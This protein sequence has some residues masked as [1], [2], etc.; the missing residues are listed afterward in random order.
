[1]C[2]GENN[3]R[4]EQLKLRLPNEFLAIVP[5]SDNIK[6]FIISALTPLKERYIHSIDVDEENLVANIEVLT[7]EAYNKAVGRN[8][9]NVKLARDLT[10]WLINVK[11]LK[12]TVIMP[13]PEDEIREIIKT[14]VPEIKNDEVEIVRIARI[15]G[16]GSKVI[17]RW[18]HNA[19]KRLLASQ[20][21][22]GRDHDH[23]KEIQRE[24]IGEWLYFH[25]WN[26]D[27]EELIFGC[28]YPIRKSDVSSIDLNLEEKT[29]SLKLNDISESRQLWSNPYNL[30]L[31]EKVTG[32]KIKV[33]E[34]TIT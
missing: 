1:M 20:A 28:L 18:K 10:G 24:I 21:C 9:Y 11:G 22:L 32:W 15:E 5:W 34:K 12:R 13:T 25:E 23:L 4:F 17:V 30:P 3:E 8:N 7:D 27:P 2:I 19:T 33:F 14:K 29:A 16:I 6:Q 31:T 26:D